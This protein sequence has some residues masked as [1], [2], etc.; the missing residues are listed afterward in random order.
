[1]A[2]HYLGGGGGGGGASGILLGWLFGGAS[3]EE[4][5]LVVGVSPQPETAEAN[6][7]TH[8]SRPIHER[9]MSF[10]TKKE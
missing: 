5:L 1:M 6:N 7:T 2:C 8:N 3:G 4:L 10:P 9:M